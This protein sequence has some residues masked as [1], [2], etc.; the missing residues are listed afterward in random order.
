MCCSFCVYLFFVVCRRLHT[1]C[2]LVTGVQTCALPI[3][4]F[5]MLQNQKIFFI[6][7]EVL[8][9]FVI[10]FVLIRMPGHKKYNLMHV[11]LV[12]VASGAI[13]NMIDRE[14]KRSEERRVGKACVSTCRIEWCPKHTTKKPIKGEKPRQKNT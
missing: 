14:T 11:I 7:I 5:G 8:I 13:G 12:L 2:A 9:L 3:S 6:F 4:A 10:A 1:M